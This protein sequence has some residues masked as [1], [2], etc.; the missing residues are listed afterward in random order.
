MMDYFKTLPLFDIL[1]TE[2][3]LNASE[4]FKVEKLNADEIILKAGRRCKNLYF[5]FSGLVFSHTSDEN[6]QILWY[7]FEGNSFTDIHSFYTKKPS[8]NYI[9]AGENQTILLSISY[10]NLTKL[11]M[12]SHRWAIWCT[13]FKQNELVRLTSYY[14]GLRIKDASQRYFELVAAHPKILQRISLGHIASYLGISQ[15]SLSRIRAGIQKK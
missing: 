3:L 10:E 12:T 6:E 2:D 11:F 4:Y 1:T 9:K 5:I 13:H 15:V 7:E 8:D 14:E